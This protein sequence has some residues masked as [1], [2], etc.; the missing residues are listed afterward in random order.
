VWACRLRRPLAGDEWK[1]RRAAFLKEMHKSKLFNSQRQLVS[2]I[3]KVGEQLCA[4]LEAAAAS[5]ELVKVDILATEAAFDTILFFLFGK[6][7]AWV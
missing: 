7:V 2:T 4:K 1:W 6:S 5:K 3:H